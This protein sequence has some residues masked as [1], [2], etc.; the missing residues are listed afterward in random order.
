MGKTVA[1]KLI[2]SHLVKGEAKPG[3]EIAIKIDHT[4]TQDATG[5]MVFLEFMAMGVVLWLK[6]RG[7][8]AA[9]KTTMPSGK[10]ATA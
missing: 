4:L 7:E 8:R 3:R 6:E 1:E 9:R 5:T 10:E 2:E